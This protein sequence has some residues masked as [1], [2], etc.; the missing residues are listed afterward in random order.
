MEDKEV[1]LKQ[2]IFCQ[3]WVD[4]IGN[5]TQS[6]LIAFDIIGKELLDA[7]DPPK[8]KD[9]ES[10]KEWEEEI[11]LLRLEKKRIFNVAGAMA[12]ECLRKPN[13]IKRIDEILE[14]R[15][16]NDDSVKREHFKLIK[17]SKDEVRMRAIDSY[18]KLKGKITD[19]FDHTTN[20][21]E[22]PQPLL[23]GLLDNNSNKEDS[24]TQEKD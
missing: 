10:I 21:K 23:Y 24:S 14:E 20:G 8:P 1:T 2:E 3:S 15:G 5:G 17:S 11:K 4:S 6:A 19:K 16:F 12:T 9:K 13:V 7:E 22:L 18:Y